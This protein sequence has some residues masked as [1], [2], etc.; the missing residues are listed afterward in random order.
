MPAVPRVMSIAVRTSASMSRPET[1]RTW[2]V[3]SRPMSDCQSLAALTTIIT[4]PTVS[5]ARNVMMA[6]TAASERPA[7]E[8][9]GTI[10][11]AACCGKARDA[12]GARS[13]HGSVTA[14]MGSIVGMQSPF[15]QH[16]PARVVFVHQGDIVGG[17]DDGGSGFVELDEE[18]QQALAEIGIDIAGRFIGKQELRTGD[19]GASNCGT[20][21]FAAREHRRQGVDALAETHPL[22]KLDDFGAIGSLIFADHAKRQRHVL[23]GG[24]VVEQAKIL[25]N[26]ADAAAQRRPAILGE[27]RRVVV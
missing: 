7:I 13:S 11:D 10:G 26:N 22:Q 27:A 24:Q 15:V 17:D 19:H 6:T 16:Q 5:A 1:G 2:M 21:L 20:L 4:A 25:E 12:A 14:S 23:V 9:L 8:P 18:A 3:T